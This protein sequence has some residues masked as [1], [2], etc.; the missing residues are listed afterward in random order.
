MGDQTSHEKHNHFLVEWSVWRQRSVPCFCWSS[1]YSERALLKRV[2]QLTIEAMSLSNPVRLFVLMAVSLPT[3]HYV[4]H[5]KSKIMLHWPSDETPYEGLKQ[6][7]IYNVYY[8]FKKRGL[9]RSPDCDSI[10]YKLHQPCK[11][12]KPFL[13]ATT[14]NEVSR[15]HSYSIWSSLFSSI[16]SEELEHGLFLNCVDHSL[17]RSLEKCSYITNVTGNK[18]HFWKVCHSQHHLVVDVCSVHS[19]YSSPI[20]YILT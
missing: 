7:Q 11:K 10:D 18:T 6:Q 12:G 4:N 1:W 16:F 14:W 13:N 8:V 20:D 2:I 15:S 9:G 3:V 17:K 19:V 5:P